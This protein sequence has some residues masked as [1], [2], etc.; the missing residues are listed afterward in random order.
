[1]KM[2]LSRGTNNYAE[3]NILRLLLLFSLEKVCRKLEIFGDSKIIINWFN[4]LSNFHVHTLRNLLEE[5]LTLKSQFD[6]VIYHHI[7]RERNQVSD[8]LS[9]EAAQ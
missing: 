9:K 4:Q 7:Y 3:L 5:D 8:G 2:G 6:L 1:M